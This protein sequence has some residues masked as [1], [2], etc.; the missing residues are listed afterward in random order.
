[1]KN[2]YL[3]PKYNISEIEEKLKMTQAK[4]LMNTL[5]MRSFYSKVVD[6]VRKDIVLAGFKEKWNSDR[7]LGNRSIIADPRQKICNQK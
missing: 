5:I 1:M 7:A 6:E 2:S 3:G 4:C